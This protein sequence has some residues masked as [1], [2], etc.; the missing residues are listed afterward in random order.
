MAKQTKSQLIE[1]LREVLE[2]VELDTATKDVLEYT[3]NQFDVNQRNITMDDITDTISALEEDTGRT[4]EELLVEARG[5]ESEEETEEAEETPIEEVKKETKKLPK[6]TETKTDA[7]VENSD[8]KVIVKP[9]G[10]TPKSTESKKEE[11]PK[12]VH[13]TTELLAQF[14][15]TLKSSA[16]EGTL[17]LRNDLKTIKDIADAYNNDVDIV[18]AT[19]WTERHLKQFGASYDPMN[20]NPKRPKSFEHDLDLIEITYAN[21]LVVTGCSLYSYVPQIFVPGDF[22]IQDDNLRYAN[23]ME[24]QVYEVIE[25]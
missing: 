23:G 3:V 6:K 17:K 12:T 8:K 11:K 24:L 7:K 21:E 15:E 20:I 22:I 4:F 10:D 25:G 1:G 2:E 16:L 19:Y 5:V 14:P 9:K 18:V 13:K